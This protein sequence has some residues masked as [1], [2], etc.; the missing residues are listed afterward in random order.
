MFIFAS[1]VLLHLFGG[2]SGQESAK[3]SE[4]AAHTVT[5]A[6]SSFSCLFFVSFW[7]GHANLPHAFF[8]PE[9][10]VSWWPFGW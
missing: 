6:A 2:G 10:F 7:E 3:L 4:Q 9:Y 5:A 8:R 1:C